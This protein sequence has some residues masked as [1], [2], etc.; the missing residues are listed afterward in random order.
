MIP[1]TDTTPNIDEIEAI[2]KK[3]IGNTP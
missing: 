1:D 3:T 2:A